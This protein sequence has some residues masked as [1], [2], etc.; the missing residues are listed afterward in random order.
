MKVSVI[1]EWENMELAGD[2]RAAAAMMELADQIADLRNEARVQV[3][4]VY[5]GEAQSLEAI[6]PRL[7]QVADLELVSVPG[8]S[9]YELKNEGAMR[10]SGDVLVFLDSDVIVEDHWLARILDAI[11]SS[12]VDL[13]GGS[14]AVEPSSLVGKAVALCWYF[15]PPHVRPPSDTLV[16]ARTFFA[17]GF[18]VRREVFMRFRFPPMN[19]GV[20]RGACRALAAQLVAEGVGLYRAPSARGWHPAPEWPVPWFR[21]A[22]GLGRDHLLRSPAPARRLSASVA[23]FRRGSRRVRRR[24]FFERRAY[25]VALHETPAVMAIA[26]LWVTLGLVGEGLTHLAPESMARRLEY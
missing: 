14:I 19:A 22:A 17:G 23:R 4:V 26:Q 1:I 20:R 9:Y 13:V 16:P 10:A 7:R 12:G 8:C 21:R 2:V 6:P 3:L 11:S 24:V 15:D 25:G 18:A 5:G